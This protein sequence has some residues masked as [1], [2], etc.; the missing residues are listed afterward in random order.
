VEVEKRLFARR[1]G[2]FGDPDRLPGASAAAREMA[3]PELAVRLR[4][5]VG[6]RAT[7]SSAVEPPAAPGHTTHLSVVDAEGNAVALTTT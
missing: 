1:A 2:A 5:E 6:E 7:P 3:G 4:A